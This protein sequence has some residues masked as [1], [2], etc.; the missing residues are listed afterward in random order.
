MYN[1]LATSGTA[2]TA[3]GRFLSMT[4]NTHDTDDMYMYSVHREFAKNSLPRKMLCKPNE[5]Q[6]LDVKQR[7]IT[8]LTFSIYTSMFSFVSPSGISLNKS[9][10]K[11]L[12][13][14]RGDLYHCEHN[15]TDPVRSCT[16]HV[17]V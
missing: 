16:G 6:F 12:C 15:D 1:A 7:L 4:D 8:V 2:H 5:G 10:N 17:G 11:L 14:L 3:V 13:R 9:T